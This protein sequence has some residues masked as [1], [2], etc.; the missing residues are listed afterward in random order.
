MLEV[1]LGML[2]DACSSGG[3]S[4]LTSTTELQPA[5]GPHAAVAPA[6]FSTPRGAAENSTYAY[7]RRF[8]DG[9]ERRVVVLDSKQST[10][11]RVEDAIDLAAQFE[12]SVAARIPTLRL[13]Y[14]PNDRPQETYTD[15]TLPHRAF[16]GHFRAA[17]IEGMRATSHPVYVS[18]RDARPADASALLRHA[19]GTLVFGGWDA[20]RRARQGRWRSALVGE[21]IGFCTDPGERADRRGAARVDPVA[22]Q[23][24]L[25]PDEAQKVLDAQRH[26]LSPKLV[27]KFEKEI[28]DQRKKGEPVLPSELGLGG[29]P[30]SLDELAGVACHRIVRSRVLSFA[31]LRQMRF[32]L[33]ADPR[34]DPAARAALAALALQGVARADAEL[35]LRANCDL[36]EAGPTTVRLDRRHGQFDDLAPLSIEAGDALLEAAIARLAE[37]TDVKWDG[38]VLE[39]VGNPAIVAVAEDV[40]PD[41]Q[42]NQR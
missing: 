27:N 5:A 10:L 21:I 40:D 39:F 36:V 35:S 26:E 42:A 20:S 12:D 25:P 11:N 23:I 18:L 8:L 6:K 34:R 22:M 28:A 30:P 4:C 29:I 7:E 1:D 33:A 15:R 13:T 37:V 3:S 19:P 2:I 17:S 24:P 41:D 14:Q 9:E 31:A 16:D 32:G 38:Q